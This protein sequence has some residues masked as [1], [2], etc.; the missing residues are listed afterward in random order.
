MK[1]KNLNTYVK[2]QFIILFYAEEVFMLHV[3]TITVFSEKP[4]ITQILKSSDKFSLEK[5]GL[6]HI[7]LSLNARIPS[8]QISLLDLQHYDKN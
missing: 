6:C 5:R 2:P 1:I 3:W 4:T 8:E 7:L